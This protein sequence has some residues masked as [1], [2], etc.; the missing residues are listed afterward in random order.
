[1]QG[2]ALEKYCISKLWIG[3]LFVEISGKKTKPVI[4]ANSLQVKYKPSRRLRAGKAN[5]I[6]WYLRKVFQGKKGKCIIKDTGRTPSG[7]QDKFLTIS[8]EKQQCKTEQVE[9]TT[10]LCLCCG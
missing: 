5:T 8:T 1:M 7:I 4:S 3:S 10:K 2:D 9:R 6:L